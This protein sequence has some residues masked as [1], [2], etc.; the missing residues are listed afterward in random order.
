[1]KSCVLV[2]C[3]GGKVSSGGQGGDGGGERGRRQEKGMAGS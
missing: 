1:M 2:L 3:G